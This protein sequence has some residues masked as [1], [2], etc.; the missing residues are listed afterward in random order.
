MGESTAVPSDERH[1]VPATQQSQ[2]EAA[3]PAASNLL[4]RSIEAT[5]RG[6]NLKTMDDFWRFAGIC[7]K[8]GMVPKGY[9]GS[10]EK[11]FVA[12]CFGAELGLSPW[13]A[14]N[15]V[16]MI[17]GRPRLWGDA[18]LGLCM[19]GGR[20]D[21]KS[22][23]RRVE[24]DGTARKAVVTVRRLPDGFPVT[25]EFS[26]ADAQRA[27][28]LTKPDG[29]IKNTVWKTYPDVMLLARAT[30]FALREVF[31]DCLSGVPMADD[32]IAE[33]ISLED[34]G[35]ELGKSESPEQV[36]KLDALT[37]ELEAKAKPAAAPKRL[38]D[39]HL[40]AAS[41][42]TKAAMQAAKAVEAGVIPA[43]MVSPSGERL[44]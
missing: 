41:A 11:T 40:K 4:Q 39:E 20:F 27:G 17:E 36:S 18:V 43:E 25:K 6:L 10:V 5:E 14:V 15:S 2:Q 42:R 31:A 23:R 21:H 8:A 19:Q 32:A 30:S 12:M 28:L 26:M 1:V 44:F 16:A 33:A 3:Q 7:V 22:Y 24:G 34:A 38:S 35:I 13:V 29:T 9:E 37:A